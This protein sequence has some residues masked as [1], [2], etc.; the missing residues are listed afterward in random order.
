MNAG[1]LGAQESPL[2]GFVSVEPFEVRLEALLRVDAYR[3]SWK[4][5]EPAVSFR[6]RQGILDNVSTLVASGV[7]LRAEGETIRF[8]GQ[9][10]RFVRR[11]SELG[12]VTDEREEIPLEEALVGVT[13]SSGVEA[14]TGFEGEWLWFP[15]AQDQVVIEIS[16]RGRPSA[17]YVSKETP[18]FAWA[19][20][21]LPPPPTLLE[22]PRVVLES[23][24]PLSFLAY[25]GI[26][27]GLFA[28]GVIVVKKHRT[29]SWVG[30]LFLT[31]I[32]SVILGYTIRQQRVEIPAPETAEEI[33]Y[34]ILRNIYHAF[35]FRDES[36][37]YDTLAKSVTGPLLE[38]VYLEIQNS[39][40]LET[41]GGPRVKVYEIALR[42]AEVID[43]APDEGGEAM[44]IQANWAT[45]GEVSHWGH[46][47]ERTNRYEA[48]LIFAPVGEQWKLQDL[49]LQ[50][51]ERVQKVSRN[52]IVAEPI[53]PTE[54]GEGEEVE[55][56]TDKP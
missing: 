27:I 12:Y 22:V 35:D 30:T 41:A 20:D 31:A 9:E 17:R 44:K 13:L 51:E 52:R 43:S 55:V 48:R 38:Q 14:V 16:S 40:E 46:T 2:R 3:E 4:I 21:E 45:V 56:S 32:V 25:L 26:G 54:E 24:S 36:S 47:H 5:E 19:Q 23:R 34:R 28:I 50:N 29:P 18:A 15:P 7:S 37:V 1:R 49:D 33:T 8:S 10:L 39:L 53:P 6:N 42:D 11:D